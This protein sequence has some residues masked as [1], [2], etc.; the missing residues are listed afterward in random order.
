MAQI[1][2]EHALYNVFAKL[3]P[4]EATTPSYKWGLKRLDYILLSTFAP[5]PHKMGYQPYD[6]FHSSDHWGFYMDLNLDYSKTDNI[7]QIDQRQITTRS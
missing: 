7:Q 2:N 3:H 4:K 1:C 5:V 6:L